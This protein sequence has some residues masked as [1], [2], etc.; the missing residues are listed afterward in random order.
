M[1]TAERAL[2]LL[3]VTLL[4]AQEQ[5]THDLE[6]MTV[7]ELADSSHHVKVSD[8]ISELTVD[9]SKL[10]LL[11]ALG[12]TDI[13][14]FIQL[15]PGASA[16]NESSAELL[17]RGSAAEENLIRMDEFTL[18][19]VDHFFGFFTPFNTNAVESVNFYKGI[20]PAQYGSRTSS[21]S[22]FTG[23]SGDF[24][25]FAAGAKVGLLSADAYVEVPIADRASLFFAFRRSFTDLMQT[26][27]YESIFSQFDE[28]ENMRLTFSDFQISRE[29]TFHYY[30]MNGKIKVQPGEK[31]TLIASFY[32]NKDILN[33]AGEG[34][35]LTEDTTGETTIT[36]GEVFT[37]C[38]WG[39]L[40]ISLVWKRLWSDRLSTKLAGGY[41]RYFNETDEN[42]RYQYNEEFLSENKY[43]E[44]FLRERVKENEVREFFTRGSAEIDLFSGN[45]LEA[46]AEFRQVHGGYSHDQHI[47]GET[48]YFTDGEKDTPHPFK[49][50]NTT[51]TEIS[52]KEQEI[53]AYISDEQILFNSLL[54]NPGVR[55]TH[56]SGMDKFYL[57]PRFSFKWYVNDQF[58]LKGGYGG[59]HQFISRSK[60]NNVFLE[61]DRYFWVPSTDTTAPVI[62]A[63]Q[64]ALG[65]SLQQWGFLFDVE[66]YYKRSR[67]ISRYIQDETES[68]RFLS[69]ES[70]SQGIEF[71]LKKEA[72][73]YS[74][75]IGYT[76]SKT[77]HQFGNEIN[78][79]LPFLAPTDR[80]HEIKTVHS[81][82]AGGFS[83]SLVWIYASGKLHRKPLGTYTIPM[84]NG[85]AVEP[86]EYSLWSSEGSERLPEYHRLDASLSYQFPIRSRFHCTVGAS[87]FNLYN[88]ENVRSAEYRYAQDS[89]GNTLDDV[90][91]EHK[92]TYMG[93]TPSLFCKIDFK[94]NWNQ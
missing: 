42:I 83:A 50:V 35:R 65:T 29:N 23:K 21:V 33:T 62:E 25:T 71:L 79:G 55:L 28:E 84:E 45:T 52:V 53:S 37:D 4:S 72:G 85:A 48:A 80:P 34:D 19:D 77:V 3:A 58:S 12:E 76:L 1:K 30:D 59:Y 87:V 88:R 41:S 68:G 60:E 61:G 47:N 22:D 44:N 16:A 74:G 63:H 27:L 51:F 91:S 10:D 40:G 78:G 49:N 67:G 38:S 82:N 94:Q 90:V 32:N 2:L 13:S 56:Y 5:N 64:V 24:K 18:Y 93:I 26:P 69:G 14:R 70:E 8:N 46:G 17:V 36:Y 86:M 31:D 39:N 11:P 57:D 7:V 15:L 66:A 89:E 54:I 92:S 75:W 81:F 43:Q 20:F 73:L 9:P 6:E